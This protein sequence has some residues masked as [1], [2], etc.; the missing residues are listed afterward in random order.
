MKNEFQNYFELSRNF[1]SLKIHNDYKSTGSNKSNR[2]FVIAILSLFSF[3]FIKKAIDFYNNR[4]LILYNI[5]FRMELRFEFY[6]YF[7]HFNSKEKLYNSY[8]NLLSQIEDEKL[9]YIFYLN[10]VR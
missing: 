2:K 5:N 3:Y 10:I 8:L 7:N 1:E 6:K 4:R 9:V